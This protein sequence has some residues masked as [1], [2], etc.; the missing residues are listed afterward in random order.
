MAMATKMNNGKTARYVYSMY[1][2]RRT[3]AV[4]V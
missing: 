3:C 4:L 1:H 2:T